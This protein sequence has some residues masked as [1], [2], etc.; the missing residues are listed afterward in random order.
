MG[1]ET[2]SLSPSSSN[3]TCADLHGHEAFIDRLRTMVQSEAPQTRPRFSEP[4]QID[5]VPWKYGTFVRL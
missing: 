3:G 2:Q 4:L 1:V 5:I